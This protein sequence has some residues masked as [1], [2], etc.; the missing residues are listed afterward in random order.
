MIANQHIVFFFIIRCNHL[1]ENSTIIYLM[2]VVSIELSYL[3]SIYFAV[4]GYYEVTFR[5][6]GN[7]RHLGH[8]SIPDQNNLNMSKI[9]FQYIFLCN[10]VYTIASVN[11]VRF[12]SV[13]VLCS[14]K[15][16]MLFSIK[17]QNDA[18]TTTIS[19]EDK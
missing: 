4:F 7:I 10:I 12:N 8:R 1:C 14:Y 17:D 18:I 3:H 16:K 11:L 19:R 2:T 5:K 13:L 6:G 9:K 15:L